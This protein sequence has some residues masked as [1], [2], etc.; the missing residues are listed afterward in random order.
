MNTFEAA[1]VI[2]R[3]DYKPGYTMTVRDCSLQSVTVSFSMRVPD[4]TTPEHATITVRKVRKIWAG[5]LAHMTESDFVAEMRRHWHELE[6]HEA[7]EWLRLD[8][9]PVKTAHR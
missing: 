9:K 8:E 1:D 2:L 6:L 4:A 7:D 5:Q 3:M